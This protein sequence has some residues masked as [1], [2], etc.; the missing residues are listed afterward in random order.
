MVGMAS[1]GFRAPNYDYDHV[2]THPTRTT[3]AILWNKDH[4]KA[5]VGLST[6][7]GG[8]DGTVYDIQVERFGMEWV[9]TEEIMTIIS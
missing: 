2:P 5:R 6:Y 8:W 3:P 7:Y 9:V 1:I 4:T